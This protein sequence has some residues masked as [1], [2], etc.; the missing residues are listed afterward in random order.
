MI[1]ISNINEK[2]EEIKGKLSSDTVKMA[3]ENG[4][5]ETAENWEDLKDYFDDE[6]KGLL[7]KFIA[8][9]N[10]EL[11]NNESS[12]KPKKD[13]N[14]KKELKPKT[15]NQPKPKKEFSGEY[16]E[17]L[18]PEISFIKRYVNLDEKTVSVVKDRVRTLLASLQKAIID[19]KIRKTSI[20]AET[21]IKIQSNLIKIL[22]SSSSITINIANKEDLKKLY[23]KFS[24]MPNARIIKSYLS[25][26]GKENVKE[27]AK[28]L[29]K[30][31]EKSTD[32]SGRFITEISDIKRSLQHY[33][34]GSTDTPEI[35]S[36]TLAGFYGLAGVSK[37]KL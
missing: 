8:R 26:Q 9:V 34:D 37:K 33:V 24:V 3:T 29:L 2:W 19:K 23:G 14:P 31:I 35:S 11:G 15:P 22:N 12:Q 6:A 18:S 25:I 32:T 21:I 28:T 36:Q 5:L 20:Y 1:T 30:R 13:S 16:V 10:K 27:K 17:T 4:F 7:N